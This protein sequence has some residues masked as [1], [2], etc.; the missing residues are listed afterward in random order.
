MVGA[1]GGRE[2]LIQSTPGPR[3]STSDV[4]PS[5]KWPCGETVTTSPLGG[6]CFRSGN[7]GSPSGTLR[8]SSGNPGPRPTGG[9]LP[10]AAASTTR[11]V[12]S[13]ATVENASRAPF[14]AQTGWSPAAIDVAVTP[15]ST[16]T[17][18]VVSAAVAV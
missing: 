8:Q 11:L 18:V 7:S 17:A 3:L 16:I 13:A 2:A 1:P 5:R 4:K 14:G 6:R 15:S 10:S 9:T 12:P